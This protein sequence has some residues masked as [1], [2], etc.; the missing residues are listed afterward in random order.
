G[1]G[2]QARHACVERPSPAVARLD[3]DTPSRA[4]GRPRARTLEIGAGSGGGLIAAHHRD[5]SRYGRLDERAVGRSQTTFDGVGPRG[6]R[7]VAR[8]STE[9]HAPGAD[10]APDSPGATDAAP[11]PP[12]AAAAGDRRAARVAARA[13]WS[14]RAAGRGAGVS[15]CATR[16]R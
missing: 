12:G 6:A 13:S 16:R 15:G 9:A 8:V 11:D 4:D 10:A 14:R 2:R 1:I 3:D 7:G 5:S